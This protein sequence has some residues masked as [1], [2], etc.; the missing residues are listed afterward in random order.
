MPTVFLPGI[1]ATMRTL[2]TFRFRAMSSASACHLVD[3]QAGLQGD[4]EL[5]DDRSGVDADDVDVEAEVGEGLLQK[6]RPLAQL[7][8]VLAVIERLGVFQQCQRRQFVVGEALLIGYG[9]G[10]LAA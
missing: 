5:G 4:L 10:R 7:L 8:I 1:G 3:A 9:D 2:G 6:R